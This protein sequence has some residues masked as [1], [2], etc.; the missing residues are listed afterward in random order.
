METCPIG[1]QYGRCYLNGT[2][3]CQ[4]GYILDPDT[5]KFCRPNCQNGC[6]TKQ[7]CVSPGKCQ[8][9]DGYHSTNELGCQPICIPDCGYGKCVGLNQCECFAGFMKRPHRNVCEAEC[10]M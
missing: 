3:E 8:C 1:C 2:C 6:G 7:L 9:R 4:P 10:Y 5:R